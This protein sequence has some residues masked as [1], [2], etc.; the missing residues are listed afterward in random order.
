MELEQARQQLQQILNGPEYQ[1]YLAHQPAHLPGWLQRFLEKL[2]GAWSVPF[3]ASAG[4]GGVFY[5]LA[6]L[7]LGIVV[8]FFLIM[9]VRVLWK[10]YGG[11]SWRQELSGGAPQTAMTARAYLSEAERLAGLQN[12]EQAI[13]ALFAG[14]LVFLHDKGWIETKAWKTNGEYFRELK[15]KHKEATAMF[16]SLAGNYEETVYGS[17]PLKPEIYRL[18]QAQVESCFREEA[19]Q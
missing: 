4:L 16:A 8:L 15:A 9:L 7:V 1:V 2:G 14:L 3:S 17:L 6:L 13:R 11:A 12:Y 10:L 5:Y 19:P 18:C